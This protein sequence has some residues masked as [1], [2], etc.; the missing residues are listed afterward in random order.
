MKSVLLVFKCVTLLLHVVISPTAMHIIAMER[1]SA[2][3]NKPNKRKFVGRISCYFTP[4]V[5]S[6]WAYIYTHHFIT[7]FHSLASLWLTA[8]A[9]HFIRMNCT[10]ATD[11]PV[12]I[13]PCHGSSESASGCLCRAGQEVCRGKWVCDEVSRR[14]LWPDNEQRTCAVTLTGSVSKKVTTEQLYNG[15]TY[16]QREWV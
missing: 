14:T 2:S 9:L 1:G 10:N 12:K 6:F 4:T 3:A 8:L 13:I 15:V 7:S 11:T 16:I 5:R